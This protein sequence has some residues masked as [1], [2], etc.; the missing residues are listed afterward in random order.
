MNAPERHERFVVP[1]GVAKVS[2]QK[3]TKVANGATFTVQREDHTVGNLLRM[4][5]LRDKDVLFAGYQM[6]HPLEY[7]M[8]I[9]IQT[10]KRTSPME[11][12]LSAIEDLQKE[13]GDLKTQFAAE[14]KPF[15]Q[16]SRPAEFY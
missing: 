12:L 10:T 4:Q 6:P 2:Y 11:V 7:K 15:E 5:L 8:Y 16:E 13:L 1:E 3:D 9:R 14:L